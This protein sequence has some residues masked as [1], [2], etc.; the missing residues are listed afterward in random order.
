MANWYSTGSGGPQPPRFVRPLF[1]V[2]LF[3]LFFWL[4]M[5]MKHH[6]FLDGARYNNQRDDTRQ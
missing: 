5:S 4:A 2:L 6:H 3:L 1:I